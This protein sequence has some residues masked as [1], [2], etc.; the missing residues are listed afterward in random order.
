MNHHSQPLPFALAQLYAYQRGLLI[1]EFPEL[2]E[3]TLALADTLDGISML[4]DVLA[5]LLRSA[6][7][8]EAIADTLSNVII[9]ANQERRDRFERR[10]AKR[11]QMVQALMEQAGMTK[12]ERPDLT[13]SIRN[14]PP[15]VVITDE[16]ALPDQ[17]IKITR[18]PKK[19]DIRD[20]LGRGETVEGALLG[21]A[22]QTLTIRTR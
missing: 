4:P 20:A 14:V 8:D 9:K 16:A 12:L 15:G 2:Q 10:A 21:N 18:T 6:I 22:S 13:A 7:E 1:S 5:S 11:R 3:D 19:A 17:F